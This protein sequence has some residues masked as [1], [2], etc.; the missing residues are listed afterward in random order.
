MYE[1][2]GIYYM[3]TVH[4]VQQES[5]S[6]VKSLVRRIGVA[7]SLIA[8][9][10]VNIKL[11]QL[12]YINTKYELYIPEIDRCSDNW[13]PQSGTVFIMDIIWFILSC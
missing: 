9:V 13:I 8:P 7:F 1:S 4:A 3:E 11:F 6:C 12:V 5:L 10:K 2:E